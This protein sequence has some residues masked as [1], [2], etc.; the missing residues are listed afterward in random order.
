[1]PYHGTSVETFSHRD[2]F[3]YLLNQKDLYGLFCYICCNCIYENNDKHMMA[4]RG[5]ARSF[6]GKNHADP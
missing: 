2:L 1:M 5:G 4:L 6:F 3:S